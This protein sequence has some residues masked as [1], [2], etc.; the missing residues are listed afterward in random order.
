MR[1]GVPSA[2]A[3][4]PQDASVRTADA[5]PDKKRPWA[6]KALLPVESCSLQAERP[7]RARVVC[8]VW[9]AG[10]QVAERSAK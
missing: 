3:A 4:G 7:P 1:A 8:A 6:H 5:A 10:Q 2:G 9:L